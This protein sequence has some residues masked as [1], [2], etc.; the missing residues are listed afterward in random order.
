[1]RR[2]ARRTAHTNCRPIPQRSRADLDLARAVNSGTHMPQILQDEVLVKYH[3]TD[4]LLLP[5]LSLPRQELQPAGLLP[6]TFAGSGVGIR[7]APLRAPNAR[8]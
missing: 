7:E 4:P 3:F 5:R 1:M 2:K 6:L 8:A